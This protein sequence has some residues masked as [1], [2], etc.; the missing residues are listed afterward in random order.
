[1]SYF[2]KLV[3]NNNN[4]NNYDPDA[5]LGRNN[6]NNNYDPDAPLGRHGQRLARQGAIIAH[7]A[8]RRLRFDPIAGRRAARERLEAEARSGRGL[9]GG[10]RQKTKKKRR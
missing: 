6:N 5:P 4:N 7:E 1:M 2:E 9:S 8:R 3:D 10:K